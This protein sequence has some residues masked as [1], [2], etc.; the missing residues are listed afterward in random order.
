MISND[1]INTIIQ[2][3]SIIGLASNRLFDIFYDNKTFR[4]IYP[5]QEFSHAHMGRL[6]GASSHCHHLKSLSDQLSNV[7]ALVSN[8][9]RVLQ[10]I[11]DLK[12]AYV[13]VGSQIRHNN[14]LP[15][16]YKAQSMSIL[17]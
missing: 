13:I 8:E 15:L 5:E 1:L 12:D 3:N 6:Y 17:K 14:S 9:R 7:R 10:L 16:F 2:H 4:A 11:S